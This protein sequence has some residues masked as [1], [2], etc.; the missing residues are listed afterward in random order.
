MKNKKILTLTITFLVSF[1]TYAGLSFAQ[2]T[3]IAQ[4]NPLFQ[5]SQTTDKGQTKIDLI[6]NLPN[7]TLNELTAGII[8]ILLAI[9][10]SLAL[11]S[12]T[13][14]GII[15]ITAQGDETKISKGK[16]VLIW[17]IAGLAVI[18]ISYGIVVGVS[19]LQFFGGAAPAGTQALAPGSEDL[20]P[21]EIGEDPGSFGGKAI[22]EP[23]I[24]K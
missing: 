24:P 13:V 18:A 9:C 1:W 20:K 11:V 6:N 5:P 3:L 21:N 10:G 19:Q 12:F 7:K 23:A 14:G 17:S 4:Q 15:M 8:K 2:N 16:M 22:K